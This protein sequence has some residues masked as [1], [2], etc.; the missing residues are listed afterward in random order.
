[1]VRLVFSSVYSNSMHSLM[2]KLPLWSLEGSA[3]ACY[4]VFTM[5]SFWLVKW[6]D[7]ML[8]ISDLRNFSGNGE[9]NNL[10]GLVL[11][12]HLQDCRY[13]TGTTQTFH[14]DCRTCVIPVSYLPCHVIIFQKLL[15]LPWRTRVYV[16]VR[17]F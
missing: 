14:L 10:C 13:H 17:T 1:M 8:K 6:L 12:L 3:W 7:C 4:T 16:R 2:V 11:C 15:V 5:A 9:H